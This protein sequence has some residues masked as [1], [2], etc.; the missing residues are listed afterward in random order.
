MAGYDEGD[1]VERV[2]ALA[3][4]WSDGVEERF[5]EGVT[6]GAVAIVYEL[7]WPDGGS[8]VS[9]SSSDPRPWFQA[10]LF[11]RALLDADELAGS[12]E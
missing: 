12:D 6:V 9:Y 11:R 7:V 3:R 2:S 4:D 8:G 1:I 5:G 10:G